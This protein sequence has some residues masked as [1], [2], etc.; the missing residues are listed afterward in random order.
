MGAFLVML[1]QTAFEEVVFQQDV[2]DVKD[3]PYGS[4]GTS[5]HTGTVACVDL[6]QERAWHAG[7][8]ARR[9]TDWSTS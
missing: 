9:Q 5:I 6:R 8:I 1:V 4:L 2:N 3:W 7:G